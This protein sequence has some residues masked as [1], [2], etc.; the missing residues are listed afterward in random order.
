[1][2]SLVLAIFTYG[3][4]ERMME[5]KATGMLYLSNTYGKLFLSGVAAEAA[6]AALFAL[7]VVLF[8]MLVAQFRKKLGGG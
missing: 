5:Y 6:L 4:I 3:F 7:L 1:M 2:W 8:V